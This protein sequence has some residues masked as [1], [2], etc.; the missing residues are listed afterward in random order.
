MWKSRTV[1]IVLVALISVLAIHV[2]LQLTQ[3]ARADLTAENLYSLSDGTE[4]ILERMQREGTE[5]IEM[6]L[7]F[8]ETSGKTLPRFI[9]DFITYERYL[10]HLLKEYERA[11]KGKIKVRFID[12]ITDSDDEQD[13][14]KDG[15]EGRPINQHGDKFFFGLTVE[16]QTGSKETIPFLWP[17]EQE[18]IEYEITK[19]LS[20]LLWPPSKKIGVLSSLE[21]FGGDDNPYLAQMLAAQGRTPPQKWISIQLLEQSYQVSPVSPDTDHLSHDDYDLVLVIH[22]KHLSEKALWALDEWVVTG[23]KTIVFLDPYSIADQAPQNPQQPWMA[24]QY[25]PAS[26]LEPLLH[27]WGL[28]MPPQTFAADLD[29]A[30]RRPVVRG[31]PAEAVLVDLQVTEATRD[32]TLHDHPALKGIDNVR[33]FLA[34]VLQE[35][36]A[37]D[38]APASDGAQ[39]P[40]GAPSSAAAAAEPESGA[41]HAAAPTAAAPNAGAAKPNATEGAKGDGIDR[42]PLITTT[43]AGSTLEIFP[44]FGGEGGGLYYTD[45]NNAAKLQDRYRPGDQSQV[46]AWQISGRLPSAFPKGAELPS[47]A[48]PQPEGLP[49]GIELPPPEGTERVHKDPVPD[50]E[51]RDA[52]VIVFSDVDLIS[53]P[54][55]F[56]RNILGIV[57]AA[58]DNHQVLLNSVDHLLGAQELMQVRTARHL[59]R[60]FTRFD[61]IEAAAEKQTLEREREIREQVE[62]FQK[63]LQAKQNEIT[64]RNAALL[65]RKVQ[66]DVDGLNERIQAGNAELRTIR[67]ERRAALEGQ[68]QAVRLSVLGWM[69]TLVLV[70]GLGLL[71]RRKRMELD[72]KRSSG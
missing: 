72:A 44:G 14:I 23:G 8:S 58:N 55:A 20:S 59:D 48:P 42:V 6:R 7:Y 36:K 43:T 11:G 13:A 49:P 69:P 26:S 63:E 17:N 62:G 40:G 64:E 53:D 68:E 66:Q 45:L 4:R 33:F 24:L 1:T 2:V 27:A 25:E 34:G 5:P 29:L 50:A 39:A 41:A 18:S 38:G 70:L 30:V 37:D 54:L 60:P 71:V 16:T 67:L 21:V 15:L 10:R 19:R 52:T 65:Q 46:L 12:P 51:R 28:E 56:Q 61:E 9:K 3:G 57:N 35:R 47:T 22:P 32:A 31:G